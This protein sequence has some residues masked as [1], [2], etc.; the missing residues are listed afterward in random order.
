MKLSVDPKEEF[1]VAVRDESAE[2]EPLMARY[3][4]ARSK[5]LPLKTLLK[6]CGGKMA[7]CGVGTVACAAGPSAAVCGVRGMATAEGDAIWETGPLAACRV[8]KY[9]H[10]EVCIKRAVSRTAFCRGRRSAIRSVGTNDVIDRTSL[11][12]M[13]RSV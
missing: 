11:I 5:K 8:A 4:S 7:L 3:V 6:G 12:L 1:M 10:G 2:L 13:R 9:T